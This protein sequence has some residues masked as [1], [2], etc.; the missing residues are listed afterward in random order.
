[1]KARIIK[2][3][4]A[5]QLEY[6]ILRTGEFTTVLRFKSGCL[7]ADKIRKHNLVKTTTDNAKIMAPYL[8][9]K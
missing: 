2:E 6:F 7:S 5:E 3:R 8:F 1:M 4:K 9:T